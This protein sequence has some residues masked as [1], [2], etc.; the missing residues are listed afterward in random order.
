M[1]GTRKYLLNQII[2]WATDQSTQKDGGNMF[3]IY[4]LPGIGKPSLA[5]SIYKILHE[6]KHFSVGETTRI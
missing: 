3:W 5:H 2:T 4:G 6:R 1:E